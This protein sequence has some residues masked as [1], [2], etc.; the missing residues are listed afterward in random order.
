MNKLFLFLGDT[1]CRDLFSSEPI[2]AG[3]MSGQDWDEVTAGLCMYMYIRTGKHWIPK[4][5]T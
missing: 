2:Q 4:D 3:P 1:C 5:R